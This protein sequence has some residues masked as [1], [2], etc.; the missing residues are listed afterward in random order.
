VWYFGYSSDDTAVNSQSVNLN[1]YM[2][3]R[4]LDAPGEGTGYGGVGQTSWSSARPARRDRERIQL[5]SAPAR[6]RTPGETRMGKR[7]NKKKRSQKGKDVLG[8]RTMI[9]KS[10]G[11]GGQQ[12]NTQEM[13][14]AIDGNIDNDGVGSAS[15]P[16]AE[17]E[18]GS[19]P[20][21][22][23]SAARQAEIAG[24][25]L[26]KLKKRHVM[27]KRQMRRDVEELRRNKLGLK[28]HGAPQQKAERKLVGQ[29]MQR[30][31]ADLTQR[32]AAEIAWV[33]NR[34]SIDVDGTCESAD[35][36]EAMSGL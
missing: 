5:I 3:R 21:P 30:M 33:K 6:A 12:H 19:L 20:G 13:A 32:H 23:I 8:I 15:T 9:S 35:E 17:E 18:D 28:R 4:P 10:S 29:Q 11:R 16:K 36:M 14:M 26:G 2:S 27:E 7:G 25:S 22:A 31:E 34:S 24:L 1:L